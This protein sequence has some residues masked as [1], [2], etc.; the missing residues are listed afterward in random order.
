MLKELSKA[1]KKKVSS[2]L[3]KE[4][5][6]RKICY[7]YANVLVYETG[8]VKYKCPS[9]DKSY[10]HKGNL[11]KHIKYEC[12]ERRPFHCTVCSYS[13]KQKGNLKRHMKKHKNSVISSY[14]NVLVE[15]TGLEKYK[16][17]SCDKSY[18]HKGNLNKHIKYE[19]G[20]RRPFRCT[21]CSYSAKQKGNLKEHMK[22]HKNSVISS[23]AKVLVDETGL[24]KYKCPS[25]D[26][27]YLHKG[28]LNKHIK[29]EC[30]ER[31]PFHC[32][33]CSYSAKQK[34]NLKLHMK[35]HKNS[36]ISSSSIL[37]QSEHGDV[38]ECLMCKKTFNTKLELCTHPCSAKKK[39]NYCCP[40]CPYS[41]R[42]KYMVSHHIMKKHTV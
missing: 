36:V 7:V 16:C 33:V 4:V 14:A 42:I 21:V 1:L 37:I 15:E 34:G 40:F 24:E 20:E 17:P 41:A 27:S 19:C 3:A 22:K 26:K 23:Y 10:L 13:A 39:N 30:G 18:L 35:K 28:N 6:R 25:C 11:N 8:L 31:R 5:S 12:G 38:L 29:Y 32:T 2:M 9:C